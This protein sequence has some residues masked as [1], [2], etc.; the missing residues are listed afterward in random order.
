MGSEEQYRA[1]ITAMKY[2]QE[3]AQREPESHWYDSVE[4]VLLVII[5][6][7]AVGVIA[8]VALATII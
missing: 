8:G 4:S 6:M 7:V 1:G 2:R 3:L 5:T